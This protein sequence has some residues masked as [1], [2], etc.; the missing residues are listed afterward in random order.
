MSGSSL[1]TLAPCR[2]PRRGIQ[3]VPVPI[4]SKPIT[5]GGEREKGRPFP[6]SPQRSLLR[7][8]LEPLIPQCR[9]SVGA[10]PSPHFTS[11]APHLGVV[12]RELCESEIE[13]LRQFLLCPPRRSGRASI[14]P[15]RS[16]GGPRGRKVPRP[17]SL[18]LALALAA[19]A[20][21]RRPARGKGDARPAHAV[22][23]PHERPCWSTRREPGPPFPE[24]A[25]G[26]RPLRPVP[27]RQPWLSRSPRCLRVGTRRPEPPRSPEK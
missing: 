3:G 16:A 14:S 18:A 27:T 20:R 9:G 2:Q 21:R 10:P 13:P 24:P 4:Q 22:L 6:Q 15:E 19:G 17:A 26:R 1:L 11:M 5:G 8:S 7:G 25:R 23:L 12:V